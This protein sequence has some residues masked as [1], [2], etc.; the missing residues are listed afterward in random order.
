MKRNIQVETLW[1]DGLGLDIDTEVD[2]RLLLDSSQREKISPNTKKFFD[3]RPH[4]GARVNLG[5]G[6]LNHHKLSER[7]PE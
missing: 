7:L 5:S 6:Y 4:L 3:S 2:I 1:D